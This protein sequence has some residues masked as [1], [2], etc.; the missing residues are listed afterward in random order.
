MAAPPTTVVVVD[1]HDVFA[2]CLVQMIDGEPDLACVGSAATIAEATD[3]L[4]RA[5][6]DVLLLDVGLPDGDGIAAIPDLLRAHDLM[7]VLVLTASTSDHVL[8]AAIEA[9]ASGYLPKTAG[10]DEVTSAVR[11]AAAD[12]AVISPETLARL[13]PRLRRRNEAHSTDLTA[14]ELEVLGLIGQGLQNSAIADTLHVSPHTVNNH[15][16]SLSRKLGAH[17]KLEA[18][19][20]AVRTGL[21]T[22]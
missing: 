19:S 18:L 20:I 1:D 3:I 11:S 8:V 10:L 2:Q 17:S 12:E 4:R 9:G 13:L 6:P 7:K 14:R 16:A 15:I 21:V 22:V 5:R